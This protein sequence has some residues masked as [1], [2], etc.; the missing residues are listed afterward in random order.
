MLS[1]KSLSEPQ[2][3]ASII[4]DGW[5]LTQLPSNVFLLVL[6]FGLQMGIYGVWSGVLPS[7][8]LSMGYDN[9]QAGTLGSLNTFAG[10]FGGVGV[11]LLADL[12]WCR[13]SLKR[14]LISSSLISCFFFI[15]LAL[16]LPPLKM[17]TS[18]FFMLCLVSSLAG[19]V[20]GMIDPI[21]FELCTELSHPISPGVSGTV[22]TLWV[23]ILMIVC[24]SLPA[25]F[26]DKIMMLLMAGTMGLCALLLF[27]VKEEYSRLRIDQGIMPSQSMQK[28][29]DRESYNMEQTRTSEWYDTPSSSRTTLTGGRPSG[30]MKSREN[31]STYLSPKLLSAPSS[32]AAVY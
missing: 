9:T 13:T 8:L 28:G 18:S 17:M 2:S 14:I 5:T 10:I 30:S 32:A 15:I 31:S 7:T 27:G 12:P 21:A 20:R 19:L 26:L 24:L 25:A 4:R 29:D 16:M 23:H 3:I 11:G 1:E 22:L 6:S